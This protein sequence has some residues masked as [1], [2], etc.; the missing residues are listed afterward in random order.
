MSHDLRERLARP[1]QLYHGSPQTPPCLQILML[2]DEYVNEYFVPR[3]E[4]K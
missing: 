1:S 4:L 2:E 3:G